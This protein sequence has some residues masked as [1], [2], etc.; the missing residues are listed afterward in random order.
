M[1]AATAV[2]TTTAALVAVTAL[3]RRRRL[4]DRLL[5]LEVAIVATAATIATLPANG[6]SDRFVD[7]VLVLGLVGFTST[8]AAARYLEQ[9]DGEQT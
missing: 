2:I 8:L 6:G 1:F 4:A 9:H 7:L 3:V 5:G